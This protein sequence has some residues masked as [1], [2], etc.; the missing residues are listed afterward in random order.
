MFT[1]HVVTLC[2]LFFSW[3]CNL[4][5]AGTLV[6]VIHDFADIPLEVKPKFWFDYLITLWSCRE[7][8]WW[9]TWRNKEL[10]ILFSMCLHSV[11]SFL[12]LV[13][14]LIVS[15]TTP[16]MWRSLCC[17]CIPPI[18]SS[19]GCWSVCRH[20]TLSGLISLSVSQ[21]KLGTT[22]EYAV[23]SFFPANPNHDFFLFSPLD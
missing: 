3:A 17:Q 9:L 14:C 20:F 15:S 8:K 13:C 11:G 7:L 16:H 23:G 22:M 5:R 10:R 4:V 18:T 19:M 6:L 1:H 21:Y 2:L 12:E